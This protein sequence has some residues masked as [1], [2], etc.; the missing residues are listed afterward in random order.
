MDIKY[1]RDR[2]ARVVMGGS[3]KNNEAL[4]IVQR[5]KVRDNHLVLSSGVWPDGAEG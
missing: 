3:H 5:I 4:A 2:Y 1:V